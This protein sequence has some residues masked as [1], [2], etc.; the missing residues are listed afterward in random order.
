MSS[1]PAFTRILAPLDGSTLAERGL[2]YATRLAKHLN[3]GLTLLRVVASSG[4]VP[5]A[6][7]YLDA[8]AAR[9]AGAGARAASEI[10]QGDAVQEILDAEHDADLLVLTTH[11]ASGVERFFLGSVADRVLRYGRAPMFLARAF[12]PPVSSLSP[13]LVPLDGSSHAERILPYVTLFARALAADV[14]V[15]RVIHTRAFDAVAYPPQIV[16]MTLDWERTQSAEYVE[17][18]VRDLRAAGLRVEGR[19][20]EAEPYQAI[21]EVSGE[22]A[23]GFIAMATRGRTGLARTLLG[24]V[25][26]QV[27]EQAPDP[28]F[29]LRV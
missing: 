25:A 7:S 28:V 6:R 21:C 29:L 16:Q 19:V 12:H 14:K 15:L 22:Q 13:I 10:R 18:V 26:A 20:R 8:A 2:D 9:A 5:A 1:Q 27:S 3:L 23:G 4:D 24:S 17:R 11:G